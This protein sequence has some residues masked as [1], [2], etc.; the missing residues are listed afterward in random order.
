MPR[1]LNRLAEELVSEGYHV[2]HRGLA[3]VLKLEDGEIHFVAGD[4]GIWEHVFLKNGKGE[5]NH[6]TESL[7]LYSL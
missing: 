4:K 1:E 2:E 7:F 3:I 5:P 6:A